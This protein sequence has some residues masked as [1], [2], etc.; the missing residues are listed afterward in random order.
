MLRARAATELARALFS[1]CFA[2]LA[3]Y[4]PEELGSGEAEAEAP[5]L[6]SGDDPPGIAE[7]AEAPADDAEPPERARER[8]RHF[9]RLQELERGPIPPPEGETWDALSK[10]LAV[11]HFHAHSRARLDADQWAAL[12]VL[13]EQAVAEGAPFG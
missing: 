13:I 5:A 9:A 10:A 3:V 11:R 12:T 7:G 6:V 4:S 8:N 2:G 1:D